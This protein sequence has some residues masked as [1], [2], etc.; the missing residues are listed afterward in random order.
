[1]LE[2]LAEKL[3]DAMKRLAGKAVVDRQAVEEFVKEMQRALIAGDVGVELVFSLSERIRK[4]SLEENQLIGLSLKD[5][6]LK[7]IYEEL[8]G[9]VG[10]GTPF[11]TSKRPIRIMMC[12]LFAAGKTTTSGKLALWFKK[13]GL[14]VALVGADIYRP[15]A[16]EQ[17]RQLS[18]QTGVDYLGEGTD[19]LG[20]VREASE[21]FA[22]HD[23]VIYDTAGRNA[24]DG[25]MLQELLRVREIAKPTD[26]FLVVAADIGQSAGRQATEFSKVGLSGVIVTKIEGTAKGGGAITSC[27]S[28][29][30]PVIFVGTGEKMG[31]LDIFEP[32]GFVSRMLG[33]G[34]VSALLRKAEEIAKESSL[35]PEDIM[36]SFNL[37]TFYKQL[38][39]AKSMGPLKNVLQMLGAGG[40]VPEEMLVKSETKLKK[41]KHI[42][43]SMSRKER[44]D[45]DLI[46]GSRIARIAK[47]SGVKESEVRELLQHY[48]QAEKMLKLV[49]KGRMPRDFA[50]RFGGSLPKGFGGL[51]GFG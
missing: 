7:V 39:A 18:A 30:A 35:N 2:S 48:K 14:K 29:G 23:A 50:K 26:T 27:A 9:I 34:D 42:M 11:D 41:Y 33:W 28:A 44:F 47:G 15:A 22:R 45:P 19:I 1:M 12:G 20:I 3:Q 8:L 24:F 51:G 43:D 13:R 38:E 10:K 37:N 49:K 31:D 5:H 6:V 16:Q 4:R 21:K 40:Q 36:N 25:E 32:K 46:D 17:L